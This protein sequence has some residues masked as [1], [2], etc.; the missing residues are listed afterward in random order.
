MMGKVEATPLTNRQ[1]NL[2]WVNGVLSQ[3][4]HQ[5]LQELQGVYEANVKDSF[6]DF[7]AGL[8]EKILVSIREFTPTCLDYQKRQNSIY[9]FFCHFILKINCNH[10]PADRAVIFSQK[11]SFRSILCLSTEL[12]NFAYQ[13]LSGSY[14]RYC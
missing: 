14:R 5:Q 7:E 1:R 11:S 2:S 10:E 4:G 6:E 9:L 12:F 3:M 13:S 8:Q